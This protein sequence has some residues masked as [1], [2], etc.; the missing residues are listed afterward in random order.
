MSIFLVR[1]FNLAQGACQMDCRCRS[2]TA[3]C[4]LACALF[5][6]VPTE[7][8]AQESTSTSQNSETC[9]TVGAPFADALHTPHWNGWGVDATQRRF[10]PWE[11][12]QLAARDVPR[13]KL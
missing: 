10:Q 5:A 4:A 12:A 2:A 6:A 11:M 9:R 8:R 1:P 7:A 3:V 13:L